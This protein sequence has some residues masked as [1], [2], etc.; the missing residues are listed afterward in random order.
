M[1][2][3][4]TSWILGFAA[5]GLFT[6][7]AITGCNT[8]E[9]RHKTL[10]FFFDGV[11][12]PADEVESEGQEETP[13]EAGAPKK[14][15]SGSSHP[16]DEEGCQPC[17]GFTKGELRQR[18]FS[19]VGIRSIDRAWKACRT[20]H[21][22]ADKVGAEA[23]IVQEGA[24]LHGPVA[25]GRCQD[26]HRGHKSRWPHLLRAERQEAICRS[27]HDTLATRSG[28][29]AG[30]DCVTCHDPHA[31]P[32][33]LAVY[34][35]SGGEALCLT[36]HS[37]DRERRPWLHGPLAV[38]ACAQCHDAHGRPGS[39]KHVR[40]PIREACLGCHEEA[41]LSI[42][43][44]PVASTEECDGCHDPHAARKAADLFL[45]ERIADEHPAFLPAK[46]PG[47]TQT[48]ETPAPTEAD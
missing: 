17:H 12:D 28:T 8:P 10:S 31:A 15:R 44:H 45:R 34:Q 11:P 41:Q 38:K 30:F 35:R 42:A 27:C 19:G 16:A 2:R 47:E 21:S 33:A 25:V 3:P 22:Q 40:R 9:K 13:G 4:G 7:C 18:G 37:V 48:E 5:A 29:M 1:P 24:W 46:Q 20:C 6:A 26:C 23:L 36:C 14:Q 39:T 32:S 43:S